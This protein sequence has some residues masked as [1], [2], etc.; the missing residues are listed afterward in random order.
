M[1]WPYSWLRIFCDFFD[2]AANKVEHGS[3]HEKFAVF[4]GGIVFFAVPASLFVVVVAPE[5]QFLVFFELDEGDAWDVQIVIIA[6]PQPLPFLQD[7]VLK[8]L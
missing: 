7:A 3:F 1:P 6:I 2:D 5:Y 4:F 8:Q